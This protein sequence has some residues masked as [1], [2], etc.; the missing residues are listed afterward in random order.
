VFFSSLL[1]GKIRA[2]IIGGGWLVILSGAL[3]LIF[4]SFLGGPNLLGPYWPVLIILIGVISLV[5]AFFRR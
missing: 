5:Q 1:Q 2:A 4:G 3:F